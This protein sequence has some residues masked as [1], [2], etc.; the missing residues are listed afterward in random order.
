MKRAGKVLIS[1]GFILVIGI[2]NTE[3]PEKEKKQ[4]HAGEQL[5]ITP[6]SFEEWQAH[7]ASLGEHVTRADWNH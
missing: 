6:M 1:L 2:T 5:I 3:D 7:R 4:V